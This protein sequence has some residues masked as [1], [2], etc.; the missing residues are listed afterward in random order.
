[1]DSKTGTIEWSMPL[2]SA[3]IPIVYGDRTDLMLIW[4][5][6]RSD[7]D[8][9]VTGHKINVRLVNTGT[10]AILATQDSISA[11][12]PLRCTHIADKQA[13]EI[14]TA[15]SLITIQPETV[16]GEVPHE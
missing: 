14:T 7:D 8:T 2:E 9:Q 6:P 4:T 11:S 10:G 5:N 3:G 1:M 13:I 12:R 15:D 16:A